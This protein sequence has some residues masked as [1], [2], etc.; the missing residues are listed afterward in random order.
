MLLGN[1]FTIIWYLGVPKPHGVAAMATLRQ[2]AIA[3]SQLAPAALVEAFL[4]QGAKMRLG[5]I[6]FASGQQD[7]LQQ[8]QR[9]IQM[10]TLVQ[11]LLRIVGYMELYSL[12]P[13]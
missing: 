10:G 2:A 12:I 5:A 13:P 11:Q 7:V 4:T 8:T 1:I 9:M 3:W 6:I